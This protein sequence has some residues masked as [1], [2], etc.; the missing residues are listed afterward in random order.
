VW[1]REGQWCVWLRGGFAWQTMLRHCT[2]LYAYRY[3]NFVCLNRQKIL[4]KNKCFRRNFFKSK[5]QPPPITEEHIKSKIQKALK[6]IEL[7]DVQAGSDGQF[8][9][10]HVIS[11]DFEGKPL[12]AQHQMIN[13]ILAEE[14]PHLHGISLKTGTEKPKEL[15]PLRNV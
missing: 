1:C 5:S 13:N 2:R 3:R 7:L 11:K 6:N 8:F 15:P 4:T 12:I 14:I 9:Y 10:I